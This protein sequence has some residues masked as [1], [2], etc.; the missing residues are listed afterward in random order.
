MFFAYNRDLPKV[1]KYILDFLGPRDLVNAKQVCSHWAVSVRRYILQLDANRTSDLMKR[2]FL[3]PVPFHVVL[4]V[5]KTFRYLTV[6]DRKEVYI[7]GVDRIMQLNAA[8][9]QVNKTMMFEHSKDYQE[10]LVRPNFGY[11]NMLQIHA[12]KEGSRFLVKAPQFL[13]HPSSGRG[14]QTLECWKYCSSTDLLIFSGSGKKSMRYNSDVVGTNILSEKKKTKDNRYI[15]KKTKKSVLL[16]MKNVLKATDIFQLGTDM[17]MFTAQNHTSKRCTLISVAHMRM[18]DSFY[19]R[20]IANIQMDHRSLELRIV[21]TRVFCYKRGVCSP[22]TDTPENRISQTNIAVFD[23]WNPDSV[24][25]DGM[26]TKIK[27]N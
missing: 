22:Y 4:K 11:A 7:L 15:E 27:H 19:V 17:Y 10:G 9:L 12:N 26:F 13:R 6:N 18:A 8:S 25:S 20:N 21:G 5:P 24:E 23:I 3:E 1:E 14:I 16:K 2:A